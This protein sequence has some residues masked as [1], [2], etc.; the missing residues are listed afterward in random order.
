MRRCAGVQNESRPIDMCHEISQYTPTITHAAART[1]VY[2]CQRDEAC[3]AVVATAGVSYRS[4]VSS[5]VA[6]CLNPRG[7]CSVRTKR[8]HRIDTRGTARWNECR[9]ERCD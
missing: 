5:V 4:R 2:A 6:M 8:A 3:T 1:A 9:D 7:C